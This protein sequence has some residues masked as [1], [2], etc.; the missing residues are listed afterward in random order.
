MFEFNQQQTGTRNFEIVSRSATDLE[1]T[2]TDFVPVVDVQ[3]IQVPFVEN[4]ERD[5]WEREFY[6]AI[7]MD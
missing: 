7:N 6:V 3:S 4:N 1:F 5:D 2:T